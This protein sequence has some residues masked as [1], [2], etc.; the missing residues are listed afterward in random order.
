[1][2]ELIGAPG[3][4]PASKRGPAPKLQQQLERINQLPKAK[5]K[6][7]SEVLDSLLAQAGR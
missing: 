5:Q 2:E 1:M 3:R 7:V 4:R 6:M